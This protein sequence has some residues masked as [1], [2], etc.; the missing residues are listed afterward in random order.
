V[1]HSRL[2]V[3][4]AAVAVIR[5]E[6]A[7][8][9]VALA[10]QVARLQRELVARGSALQWLSKAGVFPQIENGS[11][12]GQPA[13]NDVRGTVQRMESTPGQWATATTPH[14]APFA[15]PTGA[16]RWQAAFEGLKRDAT[17]SLPE[18]D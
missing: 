9:G 3:E 2:Q 12:R 16:Q 4:A 13:D 17:T 18:E 14:A 10:A 11:L 8:R 7:A 5:A 6:M 15:I 1:E